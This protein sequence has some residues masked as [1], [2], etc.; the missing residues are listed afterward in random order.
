MKTSKR[1]SWD[2]AI[3]HLARHNLI[4]DILPPD[5]LKAIPSSN[6]SRW[7]NEPDD[8]YV[9]SEVNHL[10][11]QEI[12]LIKRINQ[13][14]KIKNINKAYF[15]LCDTFQE[16]ISKVKGVK[17]FVNEQKELVINSIEEIKDVIPIENALKVFSISRGTYQNYKSTIIHKCESSYFE[18]CRKRFP[19]QLLPDEVKQIKLYMT[20]DSFKYWSKASI[21]LKALRDEKIKSSLSTFYKYCRLLG[22]TN[23]TFKKKADFYNPVISSK[24]N[25]LWCADVTI[26]K[27]RDNE[28]HHIHF[29]IDHYSKKIL[30]YRVDK[31]SSGYAITSLLK[32]AY[33]RYK[34]E[35]LQLLTDGG[36]ENVNSLVSGFVNS[37]AV[38]I[39]HNIAQKDVVFSNS[40][41]ESVNKVIKHQF[42]YHLEITNTRSLKKILPEIINIY[43]TERPQMS[44]GGNTPFETQNGLSI[45]LSRYTA[46]FHEQKQLRLLKNK[47]TGCSKCL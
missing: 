41:V 35:R 31:K 36:S 24:P 21:Y 43:N 23:N 46:N 8:K 4:K 19:N 6:L 33:L 45:Q 30:G 27:T 3:K 12:D 38:N 39:K 10:V 2:T 1:Q 29:L 26:F 20:N 5:T 22:Y 44:L 11:K 7:R 37:K 40:M 18:W 42:L 13:S 14:S 47:N 9:H 32:D 17:S 25:E 28:K 15:R 16:V 34:P